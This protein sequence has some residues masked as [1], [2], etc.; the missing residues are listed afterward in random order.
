MT[1]LRE[2]RGG[3]GHIGTAYVPG[4]ATEVQTGPT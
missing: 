1:V 4:P 3:V 2:G